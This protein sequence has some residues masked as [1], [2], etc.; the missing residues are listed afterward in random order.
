MYLDTNT[1]PNFSLSPMSVRDFCDDRTGKLIGAYAADAMVKNLNATIRFRFR[2][3]DGKQWTELPRCITLGLEVDENEGLGSYN[4][5]THD[6][7]HDICGEGSHM[8]A[9]CAA[10]GERFF[11]KK[12]HLNP[13]LLACAIQSHVAYWEN[14]LKARAF[15]EVA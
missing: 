2:T 9:S 6:H 3:F 10:F 1:F 15:M 5:R 7:G 4:L 8:V 13:M 14:Q 11:G 12:R